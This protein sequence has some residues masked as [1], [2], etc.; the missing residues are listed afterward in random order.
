MSTIASDRSMLLPR[1][2]W[3]RVAE[4][5]VGDLRSVLFLHRRF[6]LQWLL[7]HVL[8]NRNVF[9]ALECDRRQKRFAV[10][11]PVSCDP[12]P[13]FQRDSLLDYLCRFVIPY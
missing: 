7:L 2:C 13:Y 5:E 4:M 3:R 10:M 8:D 12:R 11:V 6:V 9:Y 1:E